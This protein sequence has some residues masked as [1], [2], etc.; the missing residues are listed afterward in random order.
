MI[1]G[2]FPHKLTLQE[3]PLKCKLNLYYSTVFLNNLAP[4]LVIL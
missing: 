3:T 1:D 2:V 4:F